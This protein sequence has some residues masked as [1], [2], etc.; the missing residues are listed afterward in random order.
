ME[1][2]L[3]GALKLRHLNR[4]IVNSNN[5]IIKEERLLE[6][7]GERIREV[8]QSPNGNIFISTDSGN[9]FKLSR[10]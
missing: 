10:N 8:I 6:N 1:N 9:I 4:V 2:I 5:E 7:L 3:S